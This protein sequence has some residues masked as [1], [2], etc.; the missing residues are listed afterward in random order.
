MEVLIV[1]GSLFLFYIL[2]V[3][4]RTSRCSACGG[5]VGPNASVCPHCGEPQ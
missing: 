3:G 4:E 5:K 2:F 1:F